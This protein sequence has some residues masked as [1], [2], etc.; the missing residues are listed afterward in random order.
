MKLLILLAVEPLLAWQIEP[1]IAVVAPAKNIDVI[2]TVIIIE[3]ATNAVAVQPA[4]QKLAAGCA[5]PPVPV[6]QVEIILASIPV[7]VS[8][9]NL[10]IRQHFLLNLGE[11]LRS[12]A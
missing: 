7:E 5:A 4:D 8:R 3:K 6:D 1:V 12:L 9:C 2:G 10:R 11:N